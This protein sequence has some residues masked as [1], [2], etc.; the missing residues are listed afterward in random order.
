MPADRYRG[1]DLSRPDS[2][3]REEVEEFRGFGD[4]PG[5]RPLA[6]YELWAE[7][8]PDVLKRSLRFGREVHASESF[9][10]TLP[11]LNLY[12]IGGWEEGV[13]YQFGLLRPGTFVSD[14][15]FARAALVETL[16]VAF[17]LAPTWG[18][19]IVADAVRECLAA[20]PDPAPGA[21]S[22]WP[23]GWAVAPE[24]LRA[25][26]DYSTPELTAADLAALRGWYLRVCGEV[27]KAIDLYAEHRPTLLKADRHRWENIVREGLPNQMFAYLFIHYEAWRG[28]AA[29]L[30]DALLLG[31]G[32]G[33]TKAQALDAIFYGGVFFGAA[34]TLAAGA[35]TVDEI[36][37]GW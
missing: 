34:G 9:T 33:M 23:E 2:T 35:E 14:A 7:E 30:R 20:H 18:T 8:R 26:L 29:G 19:V 15:G 32:L 37:V 24:E 4:Q 5:G 16:A 36:L 3:S 6:S 10:C 17:Y 31:R 12:A 22:P 25:G 27:P 13:R 1:L 11:Y 21:P 28:N